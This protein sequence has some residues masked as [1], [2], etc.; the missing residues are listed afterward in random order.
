MQR[1]DQIRIFI[2]AI[3][4]TFLGLFISIYD[5]LLLNSHLSNGQRQDYIF[6]EALLF[7]LLSGLI[8]GLMSALILIYV[9]RKLSSKPYYTGLAVVVFA[10]VIIV[11]IVTF[12]GAIIPA[13]I[14][15]SDP[16]NNPE[17]KASFWKNVST[18]MHVKNII[19]WAI[20]VAITHFSI[21]VSNKFGPGNLWKILTGK[22]HLPKH[23][24]R[25]FMFIDLKSSTATAEKL[26]GELYH[27]FLKDIFSDATNPIV[28]NG[29]EIYQYVGDEIVVSWSIDQVNDK[30]KFI[31]CFFD[32]QSELKKNE[33]KYLDKYGLNPEFKAGA[34]FGEVVSGE[35]G[36]IKRD[37][38]YSGDVLN[39]TA[40][41]QGQCN[42]LK[43][44]FLISKDLYEFIHLEAT[45]WI[46]QSKG[47]IPLK[48]KEQ[49]L[50]LFSVKEKMS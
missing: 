16:F 20:I 5:I 34:H 46:F 6:S 14:N 24:N 29:A 41:I 36:I 11:T 23:E 47:K 9:N 12:L 42:N 17:A 3:V 35:V 32:I 19:F 40:R 4:W 30:K 43:S 8:G 48:G 45:E 37:I 1:I 50:E 31:K 7:N 18:T 13:I 26:G 22:Y 33:S 27:H 38:T 25:V 10:F 28:N 2:I 49:T 15:F 39:T 44:Q 21:Q